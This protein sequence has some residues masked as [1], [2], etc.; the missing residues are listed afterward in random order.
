MKIE[1]VIEENLND[2]ML[3]YYGGKSVEVLISTLGGTI[4]MGM[5]ST[6]HIQR[7]FIKIQG[8]APVFRKKYTSR[9]DY[10]WYFK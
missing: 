7:V 4:S 1:K 10:W 8:S 6:K 3:H 9:K 2:V 5:Y